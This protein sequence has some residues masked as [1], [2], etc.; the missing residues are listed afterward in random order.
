[1]KKIMWIGGGV[2][3]LI[4][5]LFVLFKG[6]G[7]DNPG[8]TMVKVEKGE[9]VDKALAIGNIVP[10]NEVSVKSKI[11]GLVRKIFVE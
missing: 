10:D 3:I 5:I 6:S 9:I 4:I 7:K 1:M 8:I 11:S 2:I